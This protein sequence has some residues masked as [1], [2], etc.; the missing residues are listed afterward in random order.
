MGPH[1]T[2]LH[3]LPPQRLQDSVFRDF[4]ILEFWL[5]SWGP[6]PGAT[7]C[8]QCSGHAPGRLPSRRRQVQGDRQIVKG[9][10]EDK[11]IDSGPLKPHR[12]VEPGLECFFTNSPAETHRDY[13]PPVNNERFGGS[14]V[15]RATATAAVGDGRLGDQAGRS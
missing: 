1:V 4:G 12:T 11:T 5:W 2:S 15:L 7:W 8:S 10:K 6:G 14:R 9:G 3:A 13:S